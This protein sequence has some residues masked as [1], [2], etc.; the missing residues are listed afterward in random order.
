MMIPNDARSACNSLD[1]TL[2]S[3]NDFTHSHTTPQTHSAVKPPLPHLCNQEHAL[4]APH[5]PDET[6][7]PDLIELYF[8]VDHTCRWTMSKAAASEAARP[9]RAA[10][11]T[12]A[13]NT[14]PDSGR[15]GGG[16]TGTSTT[17]MPCTTSDPCA[18]CQLHYAKMALLKARRLGPRMHCWFFSGEH[19]GHADLWHAA[20]DGGSQAHRSTTAIPL[21]CLIQSI[22]LHVDE[23]SILVAD[24]SGRC[25]C[26][27]LICWNACLGLA[28]HLLHVHSVCHHLHTRVMHEPASNQ[29]FCA[30][31]V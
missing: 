15:S 16:V 12:L 31:W 25:L 26:P 2:P 14:K 1:S 27:M 30:P 18:S 29:T 20:K 7:D 4:Q 24:C 8:E 10:S 21:M 13:A 28:V 19:R 17:S 11:K 6:P 5:P 23:V 9:R 3:C 22:G